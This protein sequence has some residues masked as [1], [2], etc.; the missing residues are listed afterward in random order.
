MQ[1]FA[2][3]FAGHTTPISA[4]VLTIDLSLRSWPLIRMWATSTFH[5]TSNA[6]NLFFLPPNVEVHEHRS[7]TTVSLSWT[8]IHQHT[9]TLHSFG[10]SRNFD[11]FNSTTSFRITQV[12]SNQDNPRRSVHRTC[13]GTSSPYNKTDLY[14]TKSN[15]QHLH[16]PK[17]LSSYQYVYLFIAFQA[18]RPSSMADPYSFMP[19]QNLSFLGLLDPSWGIF[20]FYHWHQWQLQFWLTISPF[21]IDGNTHTLFLS[22][23]VIMLL[24]QLPLSFSSPCLLSPPLTSMEKGMPSDDLML[25]PLGRKSLPISV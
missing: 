24:F 13:V 2:Q 6:A 10:L 14:L 3:V 17:T 7:N 25:G 5:W 8:T 19:I 16:H 20:Y 18:I 15:A 23:H 21:V 22:P 4:F 12:T 1:I 11:S 9:T